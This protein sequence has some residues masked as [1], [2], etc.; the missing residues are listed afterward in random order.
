MNCKGTLGALL[1]A[2]LLLSLGG[3]L[4]QNTQTQGLNNVQTANNPCAPNTTA[5]LIST[6]RSLLAITNSVLATQQSLSGSGTTSS[7]ANRVQ[8]AEHAQKVNQGNDV[9]D[10]VEALT[11]GP[12]APCKP[13]SASR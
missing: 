10:N 12:A 5:D 6:G 3:C 4:P 8:A 2:P 9:L 11:G 13:T 1:A 7:Y